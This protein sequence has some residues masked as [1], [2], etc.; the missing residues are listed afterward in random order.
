MEKVAKKLHTKILK[1]QIHVLVYY[2]KHLITGLGKF[3]P[4]I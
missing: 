4:R 2:F 3:R 1:V